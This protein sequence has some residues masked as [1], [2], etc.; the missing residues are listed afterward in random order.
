MGRQTEGPKLVQRDWDRAK[1]VSRLR[2]MEGKQ[3]GKKEGP[4][5]AELGK[6]CLRFSL[7][8]KKKWESIGGITGWSDVVR[9]VERVVS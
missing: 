3:S 5:G 1:T 8:P 7:Y 4:G 9:F 6:S 2:G